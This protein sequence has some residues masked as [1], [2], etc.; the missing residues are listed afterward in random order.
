[1]LTRR[2]F[3]KLLAATLLTLGLRLP[4]IKSDLEAIPIWDQA[5]KRFFAYR[6]DLA[7]KIKRQNAPKTIY[8]SDHGDDL[9]D[10]LSSETAKR[11]I[12]SALDIANANDTVYV[13]PG[14]YHEEDKDLQCKGNFHMTDSSLYLGQEGRLALG[15]NFWFTR[16]YIYGA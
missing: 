4:I 1:M 9:S 15:Q 3:L 7:S 12:A 6:L 14:I 11:T 13:W 8:V 5:R 2:R 16:N 10:G